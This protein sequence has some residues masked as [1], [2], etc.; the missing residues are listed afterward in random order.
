MNASSVAGSMV[1]K[2]FVSLI[3]FACCVSDSASKGA[4]GGEDLASLT[5]R[6]VRECKRRYKES[7]AIQLEAS[8]SLGSEQA[9]WQ[10]HA[11][12]GMLKGLDDRF[13]FE[14]RR[15]YS[16]TLLG[17]EGKVV[18]KASYMNEP[19]VWADRSAVMPSLTGSTGRAGRYVFQLAFWQDGP[20]TL[21]FFLSQGKGIRVRTVRNHTVLEVKSDRTFGS[22]VFYIDIESYDLIR[23]EDISDD[24]L[25]QKNVRIDFDTQVDPKISGEAWTA[26]RYFRLID[27]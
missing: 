15:G 14:Y 21:F 12:F 17:S 24:I 25:H 4:F 9:G 7:E 10:K 1:A 16:M 18:Q 11:N 20:G 26:K 8:L 22:Y 6:V 27:D 19:R 5:R 3:V 23:V 13:R 2:Y